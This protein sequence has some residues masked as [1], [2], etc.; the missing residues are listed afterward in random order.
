MSQLSNA[1][2]NPRSWVA[3]QPFLLGLF[4]PT[5]K[6]GWSISAAPRSTSWTF[7]YNRQCAELV[8]ELGFDFVFQVGQWAGEGGYGGTIR[9]REEG[10]EP[11]TTATGLA[12]ATRRLMLVSTVHIL[13]GLHPLFVAKVGA[14]IDHMSQG[15][16]GINVVTGLH[17]AEAQRFGQTILPHDER[18]AVAEEFI[19]LMKQLWTAEHAVDFEGRYFRA[20]DAFVSPKPIQRPLPLIVSAGI[21]PAGREFAARHADWHFV[22]NP[23]SADPRGDLPELRAVIEDVKERAAG[24]GRTIKTIIN[25]HILCRDSEAEAHEVRQ[26]IIAQGDPVAAQNFLRSLVGGGSQSWR[27]RTLDEIYVGGNLQLVGAPE[28]VVEQI[29]NLRRAGCDGIQVN[30]FD[31][32]PDITRF[33]DKILPLL[34]AAGLRQAF[35]PQAR[36]EKEDS[37]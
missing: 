7:A 9:Y 35:V 37:L 31:Y 12:V 6:G 30:F 1:I 33:A 14:S 22:T 5:L 10:L 36:R 21:S 2:E 29:L 18:Y 20:R 4:L 23:V 25:P 24:Y 17:E 16:W 28:Q 32:L 19:S 13:Y 3:Q 8:E 27:Q 34:K 15:R 26:A 11:L